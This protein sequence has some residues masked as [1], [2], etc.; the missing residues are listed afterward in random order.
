MDAITGGFQSKISVQQVLSQ[1]SNVSQ[2]IKGDSERP[3]QMYGKDLVIAVDILRKIAEYNG[4]QG[5]VSSNEDFENFGQ[6]ASNL[7]ETTNSKTWTELD[8]VSQDIFLFGS[9]QT[10]PQGFRC[11]QNGSAQKPLD[12]PAKIICLWSILSRD[13]HDE[14]NKLFLWR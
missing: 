1:L 3:P 7:L 14:I 2:S 6:V 11:V 4:K 8:K 5:N 10:R 12:K 13:R 9:L